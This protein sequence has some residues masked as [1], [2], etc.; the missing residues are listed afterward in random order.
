VDILPGDSDPADMVQNQ[1]LKLT[2]RD[3][4]DESVHGVLRDAVVAG[5]RD[6]QLGSYRRNGN[7]VPI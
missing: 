2:D 1:I 6:A 4:F 3:E 5:A 7:E